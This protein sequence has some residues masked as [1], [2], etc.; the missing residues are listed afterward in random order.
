M[1]RIE[2]LLLTSTFFAVIIVLLVIMM[3]ALRNFMIKRDEY[4]NK[5]D[6]ERDKKIDELRSLIVGEVADVFTQIKNIVK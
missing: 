1:I 5:R 6:L 3:F 4:Y 2:M